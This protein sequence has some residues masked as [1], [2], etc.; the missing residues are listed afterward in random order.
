MESG[1]V[2]RRKIIC[3]EWE[4]KI[5]KISVR[6]MK[7]FVNTVEKCKITKEVQMWLK[8]KEKGWVHD[9]GQAA[10]NREIE[11]A[12]SNQEKLLSEA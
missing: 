8:C 3:K 11:N 1:A 7:E 5:L 12:I 10:L 6:D 4:H 9:L 2:F